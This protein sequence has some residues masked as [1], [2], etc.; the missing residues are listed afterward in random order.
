MKYIFFICLIVLNA[1]AEIYELDQYPED[2]NY[3]SSDRGLRPYRALSLYKTGTFT[4]TFDDGPHPIRT[5]KIL[6]ILKVRDI[7]ATFFVLTS[8]VNNET[9]PIIKRMLDEGH[10]VA[11]HGPSHDRSGDLTLEEWKRQTK[12]SFIDLSKWYKLAG[13]EFN[14]FYY[15]FPFGDYGTRNDYHHINALREVSQELM[16]DNCIHMAFWDVDTSDWVPGMTGKE[17][18][19][20]II[21]HNEGGIY[22]DFKKVGSTYVKNPIQLKNPTAGGVILQHDIHEAS[23]MGLDLFLEYADSQALRLPRIDE[24]EEFRITKNC[25]L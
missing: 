20:N 3:T 1:Q 10:L 25:T 4:L 8:K 16:G 24:V 12:Q 21:S 23:V 15:R 7:K 2:R 13:H 19:Q 11:S 6:D 22:I 18:S 14:K 17:I 9:F 5:P